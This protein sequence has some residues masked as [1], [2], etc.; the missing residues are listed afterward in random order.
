MDTYELFRIQVE[1]KPGMGN[2]CRKFFGNWDATGFGNLDKSKLEALLAYC[3]HHQG[4]LPGKGPRI[5]L[6]ESHALNKDPSELDKLIANG[7]KIFHDEP[8]NPDFLIGTVVRCL[9]SSQDRLLNGSLEFH[10]ASELDKRYITEFFERCGINPERGRSSKILL[11]DLSMIDSSIINTADV[12]SKLC[13]N[14]GV[15]FTN[16]QSAKTTKDGVWMVSSLQYIKT[17]LMKCGLSVVA[18]ELFTALLH[19]S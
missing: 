17:E 5:S 12:L 7:Y 8:I 10:C 16:P 2:P 9:V 14:L 19:S 18:K 4:L 15:N 11:V 3:L 13:R 6:A 1:F